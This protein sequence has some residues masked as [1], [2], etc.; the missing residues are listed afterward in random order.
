MLGKLGVNPNCAQQTPPHLSCIQ[1]ADAIKV[2][3]LMN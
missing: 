2:N 1:K 3:H